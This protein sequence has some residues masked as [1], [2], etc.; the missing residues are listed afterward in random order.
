MRVNCAA[1]FASVLLVAQ[2]L[3]GA[4]HAADDAAGSPAAMSPPPY[5]G[6]LRWQA[7]RKQQERGCK[8]GSVPHAAVKALKERGVL[9]NNDSF[10][11]DFVL[12]DLLLSHGWCPPGRGALADLNRIAFVVMSG[13]GA[14]DRLEVLQRTWLGPWTKHWLVS[15][16]RDVDTPRIVGPKGPDGKWPENPGLE[17]VL[18]TIGNEPARCVG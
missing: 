2:L 16:E 15:G 5:N 12:E 6:A 4:C 11:I 13:S 18:R 14:I 3:L 1:V 17:K 9:R 10:I 7:L 8:N